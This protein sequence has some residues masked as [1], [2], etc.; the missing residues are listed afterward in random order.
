MNNGSYWIWHYGDYELFHNMKLHMRREEYGLAV[1]PFFKVDRPHLNG[2]FKKIFY[3]DDI[4][5]P[6]SLIIVSDIV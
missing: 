5:L 3:P 6:I 4:K 2:K 1:P